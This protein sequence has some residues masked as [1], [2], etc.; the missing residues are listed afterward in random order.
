MI[1]IALDAMGGDNAP[2]PVVAGAIEAAAR[3][4]AEILLVGDPDK[5][6]SHASSL[7]SNV[8]VV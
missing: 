3:T 2:G 4:S 5:I 7:P 6:K 8:R 1:R